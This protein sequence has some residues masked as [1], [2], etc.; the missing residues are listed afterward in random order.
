MVT[1]F[2]DRDNRVNNLGR[3]PVSGVADFLH[4]H[5]YSATGRTASSMH[6]DNASLAAFRSWLAFIPADPGTTALATSAR[7]CSASSRVA[8]DSMT[9]GR[10]FSLRMLKP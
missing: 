7:A 2:V 1:A 5:G 10:L 9:R 8:N 6:R 4:P 3:E